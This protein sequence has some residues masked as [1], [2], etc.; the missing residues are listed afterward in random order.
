MRQITYLL[1][2]NI[3][4]EPLRAKPHPQ[5]LGKLR[6]HLKSSAIA[7]QTWHEFGFGIDRMPEGK[8]K[9]A[10]KEYFLEGLPHPGLV[11]SYGIEEAA[12]H[13]QE[14]VRLER[15]GI[16][17]PTTDFQIAAIAATHNLVLVTKNIRDFQYIVG[18]SL[19]DWVGF[20]RQSS[21]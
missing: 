2:T 19:T 6:T 20:T 1:D 11:I 17:V 21:M 8:K 16:T 13:T 3:I 4:S 5:I 12:W 18:I 14:R 10:Y 15:K 9:E 7:A